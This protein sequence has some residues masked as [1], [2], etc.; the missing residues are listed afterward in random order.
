MRAVQE[1]DVETVREWFSKEPSLV[2]A[3]HLFL[4]ACRV[5]GYE[6]HGGM[7]DPDDAK[8]ELRADIVRLFLQHGAHPEMR[9]RRKVSPLHM[10]CR[11]NLPAAV[12][13]LLEGGA[14]PNITDEAQQTPLY[15]AVNL[16][17][18]E[19]AELLLKAG[20]DPNAVERK[21]QTA[22]HR[23]A[24]RGKKDLVLLLLKHG[25]DPDIKDRKGLTPSAYARNKEILKYLTGRGSLR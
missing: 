2:W 9:N 10:A 12:Q 15:R 13:A 25:A 1:A 7:I 23:V 20:A 24:V 11:F 17:Y 21:G 5:P 4:A 8:E 18:P 6:G 16:G 14:N 22:L 19:P 3:D